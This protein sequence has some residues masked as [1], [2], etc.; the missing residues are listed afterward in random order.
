MKIFELCEEVHMAHTGSGD[1]IP[2]ELLIEKVLCLWHHLNN[3]RKSH[4]MAVHY[5]AA[6]RDLVHQAFTEG[7]S[8]AI[9]VLRHGNIY[10]CRSCSN[11]GIVRSYGD[12][13][14]RFCCCWENDKLVTLVRDRLTKEREE[15]KRKS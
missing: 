7:I 12:M 15:L 14:L 3:W 6:V 4:G 10:E 1:P 9:K 11:L 5:D 2:I 8:D 13:D